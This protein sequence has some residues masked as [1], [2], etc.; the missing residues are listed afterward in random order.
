[1]RRPG[2]G[3]R[4]RRRPRRG[5]SVAE[6]GLGRGEGLGSSQPLHLLAAGERGAALRLRHRRVL[7]D[8]ARTGPS[9]ADARL[10]RR[11]DRVHLPGRVGRIARCQGQGAVALGEE[12]PPLRRHPA[13][14]GAPLPRNRFGGR[15]GGTGAIPG[16][17]ALPCLPGHATAARGAPC[18]PAAGRSRR[19]SRGWRQEPGRRRPGPADLR[20][21]ARHAGRLPGLLRRSAPGG[22]QG[23]DRRQ[24]RA[25]D[26]LAAALP[27]RRGPDLPRRRHAVGRRGAA[28][29]PGQPDR[30]RPVGRD[31]RAG[32]AEH[33]AA[34]A[35]QRAPDRHAAPPS[36]PWQLGAGG[37]A[38]RGHDPRRR[39]C[40][41]H[42]PGRRRARRPRHRPGHAR[43]AAEE[44]GVAH[45]PLPGRRAAHRAAREAPPAGRPGR[46]A[47]ASH[48][49]G[50]RQQPEGRRRRD[51]GRPADLRH[52]RLGLGQE[53]AGQRHA[54]H[55]GGAQ[56]LPEPCRAG[57][58]RPHRG[59]GGLRQGHQRRPESHRPH[60]AQQPGHL[61]G[62]VHADARAVRRGAGGARARLRRRPL[63]LQRGRRPLRGLRGRR[64]H[65]GRDALP[66]RRL[67]ALRHLPRC[68]LQPRDAGDLLQGRCCR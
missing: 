17:Q 41:R 9:G 47:G 49:G 53:H 28:H 18:L 43:G 23:R 14:P 12:A 66:A 33:R 65:Q 52:R 31:V 2:A 6:H 60:A 24:D 5:V 20:G 56:A 55:R 8:P 44:R 37:G 68:A 40:R 51:P 34:P 45:R 13:E 39:P 61:H 22:R 57:A 11:R 32:R 58:A 10:R 54:L 27:E 25:R 59:P 48:R 62:P 36:R 50:A 15:A 64:R 38:R 29:P 42:G 63:Q 7:R 26:P 19:G 4:H 67:R 1:V 46:P 16:C 30:Q 3:H 35:R 21:R